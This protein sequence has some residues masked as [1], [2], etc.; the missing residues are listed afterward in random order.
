[1]VEMTIL[2]KLVDEPSRERW[3]T[4]CPRRII[5]GDM[6]RVWAFEFN[7]LFDEIAFPVYYLS[8]Y[9]RDSMSC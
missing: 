5:V 4:S 6:I 2:A 3:R 7:G 8:S 1:M 9:P